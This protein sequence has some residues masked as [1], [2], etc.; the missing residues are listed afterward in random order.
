MED[1]NNDNTQHTSPPNVSTE[2]TKRKNTFVKLSKN[3]DNVN[4]SPGQGV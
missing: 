3:N 1:P 4:M 2:I